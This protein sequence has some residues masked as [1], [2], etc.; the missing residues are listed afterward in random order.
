[1]TVQKLSE[2][3][4]CFVRNLQG[5]PQF[6]LSEFTMTGDPKP[7]FSMSCRPLDKSSVFES[8]EFLDKKCR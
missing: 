3:E 2:N 6:R 4:K 8:A 5:D 7:Q 1:M